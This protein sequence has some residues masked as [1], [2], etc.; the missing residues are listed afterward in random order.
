VQEVTPQ[1]ELAGVYFD[2]KPLEI[3]LK[4]A[5]NLKSTDFLKMSNKQKKPPSRRIRV[6]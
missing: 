5:S 2:R 1:E 6:I 3:L 4:N